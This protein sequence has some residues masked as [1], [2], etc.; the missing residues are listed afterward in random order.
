MKQKIIDFFRNTY[1]FSLSKKGQINC[2]W[3]DIK[4]FYKENEWKYSITERDDLLVVQAV[5]RIDDHL[6]LQVD[7]II[8]DNFVTLR[9][10]IPLKYDD[11]LA[12]DVFILATHLNNLY[13]HTKVC[14]YT[15]SN[16]IDVGINIDYKVLLLEPSMNFYLLKLIYDTAD[17]VHWVY[18]RLL[19]TREAPALILLNFWSA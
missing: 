6:F 5:F 11:E 16:E 9:S 2:V 17:D 18:N 3:S 19:Q 12:E 14:T 10:T 13:R 8:H 15:D 4:K 7:T 1:R